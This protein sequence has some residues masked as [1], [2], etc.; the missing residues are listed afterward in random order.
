MT[1]SLGSGLEE[2]V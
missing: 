1:I 2:E